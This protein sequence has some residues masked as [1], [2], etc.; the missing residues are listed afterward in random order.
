MKMSTRTLLL[1]ASLCVILGCGDD[2]PT[3]S[4]GP[5]NEDTFAITIGGDANESAFAMAATQD[6]A[7]VIAGERSISV[8]V[9]Y[10]LLI[11]VDF[12]GNVLWEKVFDAYGRQRFF[13]VAV[14]DNGD[15]V[16]VGTADQDFYIVR[17]S[18]SGAVVWEKVINE[19]GGDEAAAIATTSDGGFVIAGTVIAALTD[20]DNHL[21]RINGNGDTTWSR[22]YNQSQTDASFDV[23]ATS[24]GGFVVTSQSGNFSGGATQ[25]HIFKVNSAGDEVWSRVFGD[26]W[27]VFP[28]AMSILP[29]DRIVIS[30]SSGVSGGTSRSVHIL[31]LESSGDAR[32]EFRA[33][34]PADQ[35]VG[36]L[37]LTPDNNIIVA[38]TVGQNGDDVFLTK[39]TLA[40]T[41]VWD[42]F[43][44]GPTKDVA[45][46]I[47]MIDDR[48]FICGTSEAIG[49]TG[50]DVYLIRTDTEGQI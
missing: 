4:N 6:D 42:R 26:P 43:Y 30:G 21:I 35:F 46:D 36:G 48:L 7:I 10:G 8:S 23:S 33:G 32:N 24:D 9:P 27:T 41:V 37:V 15:I 47:I 44:G 20:F 16:A 11:K 28:S 13:D 12:A 49:A 2:T 40:G 3:G 39:V 38:G 17:V 18:P 50:S 5:V 19:G 22:S 25:F 14:A 34:V 29:D 45:N 1:L 31:E